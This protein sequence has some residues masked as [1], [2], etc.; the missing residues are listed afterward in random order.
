MHASGRLPKHGKRNKKISLKDKANIDIYLGVWEVRG[1][2]RQL[3][4]ARE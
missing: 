1:R 2:G 3:P 4:K